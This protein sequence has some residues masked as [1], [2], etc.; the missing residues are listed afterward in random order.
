MVL[1][2]AAGV[3]Y[4]YMRR[5]RMNASRVKLTS[6]MPTNGGAS[7]IPTDTTMFVQHGDLA[8]M[9]SGTIYGLLQQNGGQTQMFNT[10]MNTAALSSPTQMEF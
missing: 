5:K 7:G 6:F 2:A 9:L 4:Y 10:M 8:T 1:L 3:G